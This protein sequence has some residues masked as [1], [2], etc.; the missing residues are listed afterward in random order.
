MTEITI[1]SM[2]DLDAHLIR[3]LTDW[4]PT[5]EF[6]PTPELLAQAKKIR[7]RQSEHSRK[8]QNFITGMSAYRLSND[9]LSH[10][11]EYIE[12]W[13]IRISEND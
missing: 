2:G 6:V 7:S 3:H 11:R 1:L 10:R 4:S 13:H 5:P 8:R 9:E 12:E